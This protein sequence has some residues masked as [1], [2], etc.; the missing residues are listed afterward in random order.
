MQYNNSLI[1]F[2]CAMEQKSKPRGRPRAYDPDA[3]LDSAA[4]IFW[5]KGFSDTTLDDLS[6]AMGMGRPSIYNAFGDKEEL[7]LQAL[8]RFQKTTG[9][10]PLRAFADA[11]S[12]RE[13][14]DALFRQVV[15]YM[16]ADQSHL[17]CL[18]GNIASATTLPDVLGFLEANLAQTE[19]QVAERLSAAVQ[20][21]ELPVDYSAEQGARRAVNAMLSLGAR[22]RLGSPRND[23]LGDASD[24]T[25]IVLAASSDN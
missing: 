10:S 6:E 20:S 4:E 5:T 14:L 25:S 21:G 13:A 3:A 19:R 2:L 15:E 1:G 7:F 22:A 18:M 9:G 8:R 24:A 23:L 11:N 12:I 16:T 17:G